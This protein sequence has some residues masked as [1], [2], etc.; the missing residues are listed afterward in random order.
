MIA[1]AVPT[2]KVTAGSC[3]LPEL[4][5]DALESLPERSVLVV[6]SKIV[7]LC[8]GRARPREG[9]D[10]AQLVRSEAEWYMPAAP[11]QHGYTFTIAHNMLTPNSGIDESNANGLYVLWPKDPQASANQL[12][13]YLTERFKLQEVAVII[14]DS[15]FLPLRWGAIGLSLD[16]IRHY[17]NRADLLDDLDRA[18]H[19][20]EQA[21][22]ANS[23]AERLSVRSTGRLNRKWAMQ[24]RLGEAE[25]R[26][27][28]ESFRAGVSKC[29]LAERYGISV[30]SVKRILRLQRMA[31][32]LIEYENEE[33]DN[34]Y[35]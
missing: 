15:S 35:C 29:K 27:I 30:S 13:H 4:L 10:L 6:T 23:A 17:S 33:K 19:R 7:S 9:T 31:G 8:E 20:L 2:R 26:D 11:A 1:Q 34:V 24:D 3:T 21:N 28:A 18:T 16:I 22:A 5:D 14:V 32:Q 25:L 12:R